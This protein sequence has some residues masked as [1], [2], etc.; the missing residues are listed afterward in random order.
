MKAKGWG[1]VW[2]E[3]L[4]IAPTRVK[5]LLVY[6]KIRSVVQHTGLGCNPDRFTW[7]MGLGLDLTGHHKH[8]CM[9]RQIWVI[10]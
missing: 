5:F 1:W 10:D 7:E 4:R 6:A 2:C 9:Y 3:L 8:Q